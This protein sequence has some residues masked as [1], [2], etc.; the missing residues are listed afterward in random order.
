MLYMNKISMTYNCLHLQTLVPKFAKG[1]MP[2]IA[3]VIF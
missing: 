2:K 3:Q 1:C